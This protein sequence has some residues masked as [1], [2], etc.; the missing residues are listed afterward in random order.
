MIHSFKL[1]NGLRVVFEKIN[2]VKS[3]SIG[4][5]VGAGSTFENEKNNG[6]S[7]F[8][9]HMTFKGTKNRS[10]SHIAEEIDGIGGKI[11]AF[12]SKE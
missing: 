6:V 2:Y 1:D 12:T 11:N 3:V 8:I 10:A 7:H 5:W 9:E 4:V